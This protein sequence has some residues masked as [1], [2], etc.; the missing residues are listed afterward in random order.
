MFVNFRKVQELGKKYIDLKKFG[1]IWYILIKVHELK[2][3]AFK[4]GS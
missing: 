2:D 1:V 3:H 4:K